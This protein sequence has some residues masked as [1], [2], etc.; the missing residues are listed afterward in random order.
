MCMCVITLHVN[1]I[2]L[3][4]GQRLNLKDEIFS[5]TS[6]GRISNGRSV[7]GRKNMY[8]YGQIP[9]LAIA[10]SEAPLLPFSLT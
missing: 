1:N 4:L 10:L 7:V 8:V 5:G 6:K 2:K 3:V 9:E